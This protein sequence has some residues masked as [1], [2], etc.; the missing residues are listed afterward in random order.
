[1]NCR[2]CKEPLTVSFCDLGKTPLSNSY[3]NKN[4]LE[5]KELSFD[6][7]AYVC[8]S[9]LLV[10]IGEFEKPEN[11]FSDYAYFSS[12]STTW[13][14]HAK[15]YVEAMVTK[16]QLTEKNLVIEVASNDGYL[17]QYFRDH[18]IPILGIEPAKNVA[19]V[20][21]SKGI[22][23]ISEF[24]GVSLAQQ[25]VKQGKRADLLLGNNVLAH[26]PD[27]NDFV[28]GMK[29]VLS[30]QGI[31]TLEFPHLLQLFLHRQFDTIYHEH[32]SYFSLFTLQKVFA[33]HQLDIFDVEELATH[34]GSLRIYVQHADGTK[35]HSGNITSVLAKESTAGLHDLSTYT[36]FQEEANL[37]KREL[38]KFLLK[39]KQEGKKVAA[40]G[41]PAKGNTLLNF[42]GVTTDLLPYTVDISP[43]KQGRYLPGTK[44]PI[45]APGQV[46]ENKP[47]Y[48]LILPWNLQNEIMD[49]MKHV[50][51]WGAQFV[52]PIPELIVT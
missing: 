40:Y 42:C 32:F 24:F 23:T 36:R 47:D 17:L 11:I 37:V 26:V 4:Q 38:L 41:A 13:L 9:C 34:G 33:A 43:H 50:R 12:Y 49:Q 1:M 51:E 2:F 27:L 45:Y 14:E 10:Q 30:P 48:I 29:I 6:L 39:A 46:S 19:E 28:E 22:P 3:L 25:L 16:L 18:R 20:A 35:K 31:I 44:I 5:E 52:V 7:H 8:S 21:E 15:K